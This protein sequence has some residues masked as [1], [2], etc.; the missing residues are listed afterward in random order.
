VP[1]VISVMTGRSQALRTARSAAWI[2]SRSENVSRMNPSTPPASSPSTWRRKNVNASSREVGP[3]GSMRTPRGPT[4][5][6]TL[7]RSPAAARAS[8][9]AAVLIFSVSSASP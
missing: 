5:P 3:K 8:R 7:T 9:A 4:A 6:R 2:S 1:I